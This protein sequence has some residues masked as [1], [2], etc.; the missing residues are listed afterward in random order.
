MALNFPAAPTSGATHNAANGLQYTYDGVKWTSQGAYATGLKDIVKL[1]SIASQFNGSLTSFNLTSNSVAV[2]P[3]SAESLTISLGG[4]IQEPQT[5][6]TINTSAGTITF[7][8]APATGTSFYGVLQSRLPL[9]AASVTLGDDTVTVGKLATGAVVETKLATGAVVETK[10]ATGAVTNAKV[11]SAAAI[12]ATKLSFT[13][14]GTGAVARTVDSKLEDVI[15][16]KDFG[17]VGN[18]TTDDTTAFTNA[19]TAATNQTVYVPKGT[20]KITDTLTLNN[21]N[22]VGQGIDCIIEGN[23]STN[24]KPIIICGRTSTISDLQIRFNSANITGTEAV[25][26]RVLIKTDDSTD[27]PFMLQRGGGVRNCLLTTCG[28]AISDGGLGVFSASFEDLEITNFSFRG[29]DFRATNRTGNYYKN[30]YIVSEGING[31]QGATFTANPDSG[32]YLSG[33]ESECSIHQLNV[34]HTRFKNSAIH[35]ENVRALSASSIHIE[36]V[37]LTTADKA[38]IF[39]TNSSGVINSLSAYYT[40]ISSNGTSVLKVGKKKTDDAGSQLDPEV[41]DYLQI[42]VFNMKGI[43][44]ADGTI[45]PNTLNTTTGKQYLDTFRGLDHHDAA[46]DGAV[47][48]NND[49]TSRFQ[50]ISRDSS[51]VVSSDKFLVNILDYVFNTLDSSDS[52]IYTSFPFNSTDIRLSSKGSFIASGLNPNSNLLTG[53]SQVAANKL[54]ISINDS[55]KF[56]V[57]SSGNIDVPSTSKIRFGDNDGTFPDMQIYHDGGHGVLEEIGDGNLRIKTNGPEIEIRSGD[58]YF[59]RMF[60]GGG[61]LFYHNNDPKL[62][63]TGTGITVTGSVT[64]NDINMSNLDAT[65]NEVDNTK[66]SWTIQ[67]GSDDLFLIN[68]MS[69]K[70]YKFNLTEIN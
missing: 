25:N 42:N 67:E 70:K 36:G 45:Y 34:E 55:V 17:A 52:G 2:N 65:P 54:G 15:S 7:A 59:S 11:N 47:G 37:D 8:S 5:A 53:L 44:R 23:I 40:R 43:S 48:S 19:I 46:T 30:I 3:L 32:F 35:L 6:Y 64:T 38:Y 49:V 4:V 60:T 18:G 62:D 27:P 22:L 39:V 24:T 28:T 69:G 61:I 66:G 26:Q 33:E 13:Q 58:D 20:Y 31:K 29:I 10:L 68:R 16:V 14:A 56:E 21:T 57:D 51:D 12:S 1:D 63:I 50:F 9:S 41:H